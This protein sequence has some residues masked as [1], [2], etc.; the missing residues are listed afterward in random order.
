M[1][2]EPAIMVL[3][4]EPFMLGVLGRLLAGLGYSR[5]LRFDNGAAALAA[6]DAP[7]GVPDVI[8][9]DINMPSMDGIEF[10]RRLAQRNYPGSLIFVSGVV[11]R[12]TATTEKLARTHR[13]SVMGCLHKPPSPAGLSAL[14][15][16]RAPPQAAKPR[17][18][19]RTY[20]AHAVRSAIASG[21]LVNYYQPKVA[22]ATGEVVGAETL[23]RWRHPEDGL[24]F[25]DSFIPVAEAH[26]L[27]GELTRAVLEG[28]LAQARAWR[29][30]GLDL[31]VAVNVSMD[32]L[33]ELEFADFVIA[34]AAAA[35]LPAS[36]VVLEVT[37]TRLMQNL[38]TALDVLTRLRLKRFR[39]SIDDF[40][41]GHSSLAQLRDIPFD[42]LKIDRGFTHNAGRDERL[43][44]IFEGS[45]ELA[46]HLDMEVVAEGVEDAGDWAFLRSSGC[47]LA[48]GYFIARPM[49]AEALPGWIGQWRQRIDAAGARRGGAAA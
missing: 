28:A 37:E 13:L 42:E 36:S 44:T 30:A 3:D 20:E 25:P 26:G 2:D 43:R 5:V 17:A 27:I 9:L 32:D 45:L 35:G 39:L 29:E 15:E 31:R 19:N 38:T 33:A 11:F 12:V 24:V 14:L 16:K 6:F 21:E 47:H 8:L 4:D 23:V 49:P 48:Q 34:A 7:S 22:V 1:S 40:G 10:V 18:P 41:T 46:R